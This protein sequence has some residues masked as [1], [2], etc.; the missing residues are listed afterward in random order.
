[1]CEN[2]Q[3]DGICHRNVTECNRIASVTNNE[4]SGT[5]DLFLKAVTEV[6]KNI[7]NVDI[8]E[9]SNTRFFLNNVVRSHNKK[10]W[11]ENPVTSV[12]NPPAP[13]PAI[14]LDP[15][16]K[17]F[18]DAKRSARIARP[19]ID[20]EWQF[21]KKW[22]DRRF[23]EI[24]QYVLASFGFEPSYDNYVLL[25]PVLDYERICYSDLSK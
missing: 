13:D 15:D 7:N 16:I 2:G 14:P 6:T 8:C 22:E 3:S 19:G 11:S 24:V 10:V 5:R 21:E 25:Y 12:T 17:T 23:R 18:L 4:A 9:S 1:M 20:P